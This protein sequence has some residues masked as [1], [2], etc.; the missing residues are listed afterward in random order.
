MCCHARVSNAEADS[1]VTP[2]GP[3]DLCEFVWMSENFF[4]FIKLKSVW[5]LFVCFYVSLLFFL[6]CTSVALS[7]LSDI[8]KAAL[9]WLVAFFISPAKSPKALL[10][11]R[12]KLGARYQN[13]EYGLKHAV[14]VEAL[15]YC[16]VKREIFF[17]TF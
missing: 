8:R 1:P 5:H 13:S 15:M 11:P 16:A 9:K 17:K 12:S 3:L 6:V 7:L 14:S 10:K 4:F 2:E